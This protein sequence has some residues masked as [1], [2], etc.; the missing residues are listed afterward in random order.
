MVDSNLQ[1]RFA[2]VCIYLGWLE[3]AIFLWHMGPIYWLNRQQT[4]NEY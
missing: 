3:L 4:E 2:F 1:V